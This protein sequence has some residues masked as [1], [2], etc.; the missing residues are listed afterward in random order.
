MHIHPIALVALILS[1]LLLV[2]LTI[3]LLF[4]EKF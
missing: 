2:Y 4:P 3:T 1:A